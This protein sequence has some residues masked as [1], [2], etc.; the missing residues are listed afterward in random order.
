[1]IAALLVI[2]SPKFPSPL[3]ELSLWIDLVMN[4]KEVMHTQLAVRQHQSILKTHTPLDGLTWQSDAKSLY[5]A[6]DPPDVFESM[7][8]HQANIDVETEYTL[9]AEMGNSQTVSDLWQRPM[10]SA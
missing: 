7:M 4:A 1:M 2:K 10:K 8:S 9:A 6:R 3:N 5:V